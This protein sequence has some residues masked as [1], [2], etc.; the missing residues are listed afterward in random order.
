MILVA[1]AGVVTLDLLSSFG[2]CF[3][4]VLVWLLSFSLSIKSL[5]FLANGLRITDAS[6]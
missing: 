6:K 5:I 4:T 3:V 2:C 1:V